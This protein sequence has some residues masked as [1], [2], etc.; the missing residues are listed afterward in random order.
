MNTGINAPRSG[1]QGGLTAPGARPQIAP[2][3]TDYPAAL[4]QFLQGGVQLTGSYAQAQEAEGE[5]NYALDQ[6]I[7]E[8]A[9]AE[10]NPGAMLR[11]E[12]AQKVLMGA[13]AGVVDFNPD[14]ALDAEDPHGS[15]ERWLDT[16]S[17]NRP[18]SFKA[19]LRLRTEPQVAKWDA[20][21]KVS[22]ARATLD[23][24]SKDVIGF[25][26]RT[27]LTDSGIERL[28]EVRSVIGPIVKAAGGD[29]T[30]WWSN[31]LQNIRQ[32]YAAQGNLA[33][34]KN[35]ATLLP[36]D[37]GQ[38]ENIA[39][40]VY[41]KNLAN[42]IEG[43]ELNSITAPEVFA[44][45]RG[46]DLEPGQKDALI[47]QGQRKIGDQMLLTVD[48]SFP[49]YTDPKM[50]M[51]AL[52]SYSKDVY[53]AE[54]DG[55]VH[56]DD[57]P[58][59]IGRAQGYAR[60]AI[61]ALNRQEHIYS[62]RGLART[63]GLRATDGTHDERQQVLEEL[64]APNLVPNLSEANALSIVAALKP[65]VVCDAV[66]QKIQNASRLLVDL[67]DEAEITPDMADGV[68]LAYAFLDSDDITL[69]GKYLNDA[70]AKLLGTV[71]LYEKKYPG[72]R[73]K[74]M[75][76]AAR[77]IRASNIEHATV[78]PEITA[79]VA[80]SRQ[81]GWFIF[82]PVF[83]DTELKNPVYAEQRVA[84]EAAVYV[85]LVPGLSAEDAVKRA[86]KDFWAE[87]L[88]VGG[89][90]VYV[91]NA[92][93]TQQDVSYAPATL[94][95]WMDTYWKENPKEA[96]SIMDSMDIPYEWKTPKAVRYAALTNPLIAQATA[97]YEI[98]GDHRTPDA[99]RY[100]SLQWNDVER[101]FRLVT[102]DGFPV[103]NSLQGWMPLDKLM[104]A[105]HEKH[106]AADKALA[107][108]RGIA[109]EVRTQQGER[110]TSGV[111]PKP[112]PG[113]KVRYEQ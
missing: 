39:R 38:A 101:A 105:I 73:K 22:T 37:Q 17:Q 75:M 51:A 86:T 48:Q 5:L 19:A 82:D 92:G 99:Q 102:P 84:D 10:G 29:E 34:V 91:S 59:L 8:K 94:A 104:D 35:M 27:N 2:P 3:G 40:G 77:S 85:K 32:N 42:Q 7:I 103:Q 16:V 95:D 93:M 55:L 72:E 106:K 46:T 33:S 9:I 11:T 62:L 109:K 56:P 69:R 49:K 54:A 44:A 68:T 65:N 15:Y 47:R 112:A 30:A 83:K 113:G 31:M 21:N 74:A 20:E 71:Q 107:L 78:T 96:Q 1:I 111:M 26:A 70:D 90:A 4:A 88:L 41:Q 64:V 36:E 63:D 76:M 61:E 97:A 108:E 52:E 23:K 60:D 53:K 18:P 58:S 28:K 57:L 110:A 24:N 100:L 67:S 6:P 45:I 80:K 89:F 43:M 25:Y 81:Q 98:F 50:V 79:A 12:R 14:T 66:Q 13:L 87:H